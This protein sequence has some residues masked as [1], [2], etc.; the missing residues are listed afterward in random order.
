MFADS[1]FDVF[2]EIRESP[3][4]PPDGI[5]VGVAAAFAVQL[6]LVDQAGQSAFRPVP[7]PATLALLGLGGLAILRRKRA[8]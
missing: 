5:E 7:D 1:F 2:T 6:E 4:A 3:T 8:L